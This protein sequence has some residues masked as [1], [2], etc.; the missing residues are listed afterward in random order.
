MQETRCIDRIRELDAP[1]LLVA[2]SADLH[3]GLD[4]SQATYV[5]RLTPD[6]HG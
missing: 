5:P 3:T 1:K 2:G 6:S 4:E